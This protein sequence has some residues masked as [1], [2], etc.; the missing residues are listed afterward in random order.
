MT[1][2]MNKEQLDQLKKSYAEMIVD[3]MDMDMLIEMAED[4]IVEQVKNYD[5]EDLKEEISDMY[6]EDVW[7]RLTE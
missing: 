3:G 7:S 2:T 6:G 1:I 5:Y 4:S